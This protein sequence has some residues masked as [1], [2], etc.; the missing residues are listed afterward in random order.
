MHASA[1]LRPVAWL[2]AHPE[3][4]DALLAIGVMSVSVL[5]HLTVR[6]PAYA[7]PSLS[8]AVLAVAATLPLIWR[9]RWPVTVLVLVAAAQAACEVLQLFGPNWIGVIIAAYTVGAYVSGRRLWLVGGLLLVGIT[10]FILVGVVAADVPWQSVFGTTAV[11]GVALVTGDNMRRRRQ[12]QDELLERAERAERERELLALQQV[13]H[14]R[15]RIARELHD[16]VA[17]SLSVMIIQAAAAQRTPQPEAAREA[18]STVEHTGRR[19]MTEMRRILGVL[20]DDDVQGALE[21]M[22]SIDELHTLVRE[23]SD[24]PVTLEATDLQELPAGVELSVYRIVQEGLTNVRRHAG[25]VQR[26][27]VA[28]RRGPDAVVVEII[29][30]GRGAASS[31]D[32][33]LGLLGMRE[34]VAMH[35]GTLVAGPRVGG[36]WR[37]RAIIPVGA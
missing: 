22:P 2:T 14:E 24:L 18:M 11:V 23:A 8:G 17:H 3:A 33:G 10:V 29:D 15:T 6:D 37:V 19:A 25:N 20:R 36:G 1:R 27:D 32:P 7:S 34:R 26:V 12:R 4:A 31:G 28:V 16:V 21:P 30:D 13:Q 35:D 9:R 5:V